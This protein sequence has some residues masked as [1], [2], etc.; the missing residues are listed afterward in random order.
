[1]TRRSKTLWRHIS[2]HTFRIWTESAQSDHDLPCSLKTIR[3]KSESTKDIGLVKD[4]PQSNIYHTVVKFRNVLNNCYD[5][6]EWAQE[7]PTSSE[8]RIL[9]K[10]PTC[11]GEAWTRDATFSL[12]QLALVQKN[13]LSMEQGRGPQVT[14]SDTIRHFQ[15]VSKR[16]FYSAQLYAMF[17]WER[18]CTVCS[19]IRTFHR[20]TLLKNKPLKGGEPQQRK[21][22][23][24]KHN[25]NICN[26]TQ[27]MG[28]WKASR[29]TH[30][31]QS[32]HN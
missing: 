27:G 23:K 20:H 12:P 18:P 10:Q 28:Q 22:T 3:T 29:P 19:S 4:K 7:M 32:Q 30:L 11:N 2:P 1:M 8:A 15:L 13:A 24:Q 9:S 26:I 25:N 5:K 17:C 31:H 14:F 6:N 21:K 16:N